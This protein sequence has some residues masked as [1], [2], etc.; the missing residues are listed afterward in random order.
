M[1]Y[2]DSYCIKKTTNE[3]IEKI[4]EQ[5]FQL[6]KWANVL[7]KIRHYIVKPF[8]LK[9]T[10]ETND[11]MFPIIDQ[12]E[13]EIIMGINDNHLNFRVSVLTDRIQ[14]Y[15]YMTTVVQYKNNFGKI[16]F[17]F[18]KPFHRLMVSSIMRRQI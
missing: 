10:K 18:I 11:K 6:P 2:C 4:T 7:M 3:G 15:I 14:T 12:N 8:G 9:T 1:D 17:L 5:I 16:Y 13:N